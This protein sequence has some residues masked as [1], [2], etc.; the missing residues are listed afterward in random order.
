MSFHIQSD[1]FIPPKKGF[2]VQPFSKE[3][4]QG[5]VLDVSLRYTASDH[6]NNTI[7]GGQLKLIY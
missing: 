2:K 3:V 5:E 6:S 1:F 7:K 4:S